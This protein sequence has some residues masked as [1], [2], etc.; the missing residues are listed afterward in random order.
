MLRFKRGKAEYRGSWVL[1]TNKMIYF[2]PDI[3][4]LLYWLLTFA[5]SYSTQETT[6]LL[7]SS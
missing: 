7:V 2:S 5:A 3:N 4:L 6:L 1:S